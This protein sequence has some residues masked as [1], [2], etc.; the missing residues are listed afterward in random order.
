MEVQKIITE[1]TVTVVASMRMQA[2]GLGEFVRVEDLEGLLAN[3]AAPISRII[4]NVKANADLDPMVGEPGPYTDEELLPEFAGRFCYRSWAKGRETDEYHANIL[5][6]RHGSILEHTTLSMAITGVSR[7]LTHE[8][9][10]HRAGVA[11][12]QE[13]Q[14]YVD[15]KT[16]NF[17]LP[18]IQLHY[19]GVD[20]TET[21]EWYAA[22]INSIAEYEKWQELLSFNIEDDPALTVDQA[23]SIRKKR[24]NEAA[25]ANLPN[26]VETKLVWT[27]NLRTLRHFIMTRGAAAVDLE[28]RRLAI[29]VAEVCKQYAPTI[30][31]DIIIVPPT[32]EDFGVPTIAGKHWKV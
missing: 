4:A 17:V 18:P 24:A 13:S 7:G 32:A 26:S 25:R 23:K 8:L 9:I 16:A 3:E 14:R 11:I 10:R 6:E 19:C 29:K 31:D 1:P 21:Q 15:A 30:F 20:S 12:S 27:A 2:E 28:I 5:E 22:Q